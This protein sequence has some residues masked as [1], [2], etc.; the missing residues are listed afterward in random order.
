MGYLKGNYKIKKESGKAAK[1]RPKDSK[2]SLTKKFEEFARARL[3]GSIAFV[4]KK[5]TFLWAGDK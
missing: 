2:Q 1:Q 3:G 4:M 5:D